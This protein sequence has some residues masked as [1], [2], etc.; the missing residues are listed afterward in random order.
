MRVTLI[1][2]LKTRTITVGDDARYC[3]YFKADNELWR[4]PRPLNE[5]VPETVTAEQV[6]IYHLSRCIETGERGPDGRRKTRVA[7]MYV[8]YSSRVERLLQ[9]PF[10]V[11]QNEIAAL[12]STGNHDRNLKNEYLRLIHEHN[13][14]PW[15]RRLLRKIPV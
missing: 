2:D 12:T 15:Y 8:C 1:E 10:N 7:D 14:L 11:M 3:E 9:I 6:P 5:K 13:S 4:R